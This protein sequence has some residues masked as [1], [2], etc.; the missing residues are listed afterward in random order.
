MN[1]LF[2]WWSMMDILIFMQYFALDS[3]PSL[4][5]NLFELF[6]FHYSVLRFQVS[7]LVWWFSR[8]FTRRSLFWNYFLFNSKPSLSDNFLKFLFFLYCLLRF[9]MSMQFLVLMF[10]L[11][12]CLFS[13]CPS[14]WNNLAQSSF[15]HQCI[16]ALDLSLLYSF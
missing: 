12:F 9:K 13:S 6:L 10:F 15:F 7:S 1:F 8:R 3:H 16:L 5:N 4:S 14:F 11:L 2:I